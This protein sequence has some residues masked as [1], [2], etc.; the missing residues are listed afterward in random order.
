MPAGPGE[1]ATGLIAH[2]G[3]QVGDLYVDGLRVVR[4]RDARVL[5][6]FPA[7]RDR[8]RRSHQVVRPVHSAVRRAIEDRILAELKSEG[9]LP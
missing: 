2:V 1:R 5:V 8:S 9:L 4:T 6:M 7:R 3:L